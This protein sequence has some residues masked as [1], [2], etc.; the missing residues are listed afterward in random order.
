MG[1]YTSFR[2]KMDLFFIDYEFVPLLV[3]ENYLNAFEDRKSMDDIE[4]M[5]EA[6]DCI[7]SSDAFN[8]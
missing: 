3:Q 7:S 6:A 4:K 8:I 1:K 5:A 2:D